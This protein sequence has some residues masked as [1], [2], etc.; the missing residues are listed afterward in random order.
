MEPLI[1]LDC[2]TSRL[3][4]QLGACPP[5]WDTEVGWVP[6]RQISEVRGAGRGT[7]FTQVTKPIWE[8]EM[9]V[10]CEAALLNSPANVPWSSDILYVR[11]ASKLHSHFIC[12][13]D[14]FAQRDVFS[15]NPESAG[16][17]SSCG[18]GALLKVSMVT[19][20]CWPWD[21]NWRPSDHTDRLYYICLFSRQFCSRWHTYKESSSIQ[22]PWRNRV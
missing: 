22:P 12:V 2:P 21:S 1:H 19:S 6:L 14:T 4:L 3:V 8:D 13:T 15:E 17:W 5:K 7:V 20:L 10:S 18:L 16:P 9:C 11:R